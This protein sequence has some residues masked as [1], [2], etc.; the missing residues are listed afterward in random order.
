[1]INR[2]IYKIDYNIFGGDITDDNSDY[3]IKHVIAA[4]IAVYPGK[5]K[6]KK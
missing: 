1:M 2:K 3:A 5:P 6:S 4:S